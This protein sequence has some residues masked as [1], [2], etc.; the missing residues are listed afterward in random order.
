MN[1][2]FHGMDFSPKEENLRT[3]VDGGQSK[4]YTF[5]VPENKEQGLYWYHNHVHGT[6]TYSYL[7]SLFGMIIVEGTGSDLGNAVG[8][9]GAKEVLLMLSDGNVKPDGSVPPTF[10]VFAY[11]N[12][13]GVTNGKL[14][15]KVV[16]TATQGET[17]FFRAASATAEATIRLSIPNVTLVVLANDGLVVPQATETKVVTIPGGGRVEFAARFDKP[18][19]YIM[20]RAP[21]SPLYPNLEACK[22]SG[23]PFYPCWS[24]DK[25]QTIAT[26]VV[27]AKSGYVPPVAGLVESIE[28]PKLSNRLQALETT[29]PAGS[30]T[31]IFK[32]DDKYP[33]FQIPYDG[34]F[35][36]PGVGFGV[37]NRLLTPNYFEGSVRAGTC[38][39]WT[40]V[41]DPPGAEH[42]FHIHQANFLVKEIDGKPQKDPLWHDTI[43]VQQN[44]TVHMCFDRA[45]AGDMIM[46]HC[47][48]PNHFDIGM[49]AMYNVTDPI[50]TNPAT[51]RITGLRLINAKTDSK[52]TDLKDGSVINVRDIPGMSTPSFN[53]DASVAGAVR[54]VEFSYA[55]AR[56]R[57]EEVPP[58]AFCSNKGSNFFTCPTLGCGTHTVKAVPYARPSTEGTPGVSLTVTFTIVCTPP[59]NTPPVEQSIVGSITGYQLINADKDSKVIDLKNST[60]VSVRDIA[61]MSTP[62]FSI[63]ALI[64]GNVHM[65]RFSYKDEQSSRMDRKEPYAFCPN[66]GKDFLPCEKLKCGNHAVTTVPYYRGNAGTPYTVSFS[67]TC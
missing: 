17:I 32:I 8:I 37:N 45:S 60:T 18:G 61:G 20:K 46:A 57:I 19:T 36:P 31:F 52:V 12:W 40:V 62:S 54:S 65:V 22:A 30:K 34:P 6:A 23:L 7:A 21:W 10:E 26:I 1:L 27:A 49:G 25:E 14:G 39:T 28:L 24:F 13:T 9:K 55:G 11:F 16:Y 42:S 56:R 15:E 5:K 63:N 64:T 51:P 58:F 38:E 59:S 43:V 67:I 4:T 44:A 33:I 2:H 53:I 3:H 50:L 48:A 66:D 35:V 47:H 29:K 41:S